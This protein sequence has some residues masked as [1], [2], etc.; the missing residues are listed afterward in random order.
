MHEAASALT[1]S[2]ETLKAPSPIAEPFIRVA[3]EKW[4]SPA[5]DKLRRLEGGFKQPQAGLITKAFE[6]VAEQLR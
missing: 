2:H 5:V 3:V 6:E 1:E 4:L